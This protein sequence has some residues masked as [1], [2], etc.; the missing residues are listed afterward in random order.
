[1]IEA[2]NLT[3]KF[4][5]IVAVD[6]INAKI[7]D[8]YVFGLIGTNGAGKSTFLRMACGI[9]KPDEGTIQ[10]DGTDIYAGIVR[11]GGQSEEEGDRVISIDKIREHIGLFSD[12]ICQNIQHSFLIFRFDF[13][14]LDH[15]ITSNKL[16]I[17]DR[18]GGGNHQIPLAITERM[19]YNKTNE[20]RWYSGMQQLCNTP[21]DVISMCSAGG[22]IRPLRLRLED[23][24]H[25]LMRVDIDEVVS[26]KP[27]QYVGIEAQ[28]FLCRATVEGKKWLFELKYTIRTHK[29]CLLR[30][31]Y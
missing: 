4:D 27:V 9:L 23:E 21:V 14:Q 30:K 18:N 24:R 20:G 7:R 1:M 26:S 28:I 12:V 29:W 25:Q 10:I 16:I 6:H 2:R 17:P 31:V 8:G 15:P 3:K 19:C 13:S 11:H 22:D 5:R